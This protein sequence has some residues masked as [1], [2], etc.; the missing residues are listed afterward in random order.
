MKL[1]V[2]FNQP[3]FDRAGE[4]MMGAEY[5]DELKSELTRLQLIVNNR[6]SSTEAATEALNKLEKLQE[7]AKKQDRLGDAVEVALLAPDDKAD[8]QQVRYRMKLLDKISPDG[9]NF[10]K[11]E[12]NDKARKEISEGLE[13][14][15]VKSSPFIYNATYK[16]VNGDDDL[17]E[18]KDDE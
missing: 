14:A 18:E 7:S 17:D 1:E 5:S 15:Y 16:L 10:S 4:P 9:V 3:M 2:D 12:I 13:R 8:G 6:A 11:V